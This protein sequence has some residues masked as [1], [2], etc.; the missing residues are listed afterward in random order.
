MGHMTFPY[1]SCKVHKSKNIW[2]EHTPY[3]IFH[4]A[5]ILK[6][7]TC[8][9]ESLW[10][11]NCTHT[12]HLCEKLIDNKDFYGRYLKDSVETTYCQECWKKE[13]EKGWQV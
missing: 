3:N 8:N 6:F 2:Y 13:I 12:C 11:I 5:R 1:L 9:I 7:T 4:Y 10:T